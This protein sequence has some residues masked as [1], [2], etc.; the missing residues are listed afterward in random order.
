MSEIHTPQNPESCLL[1]EIGIQRNKIKES[2]N[3]NVDTIL[4]PRA[5]TRNLRAW[6]RIRLGFLY[7]LRPVK[8]RVPIG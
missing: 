6:I 3:F 4:N 7:I 2:I 8:I 1:M 5:R